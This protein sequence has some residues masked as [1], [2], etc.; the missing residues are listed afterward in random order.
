MLQSLT[1]APL[2]SRSQT[3]PTFPDML[4]LV[5]LFLVVRKEED[6]VSLRDHLLGVA[7]LLGGAA[8]VG[9]GAV[10]AME[11]RLRPVRNAAAETED[12]NPL[13]IRP[14]AAKRSIY[15]R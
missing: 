7:P 6:L 2:I 8:A 1:E 3:L 4:H 12:A 5:T 11:E 14:S 9:E 10:A 15:P 13:Q